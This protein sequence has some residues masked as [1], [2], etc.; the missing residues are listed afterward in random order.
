MISPSIGIS[1]ALFFAQAD[2]EAANYGVCW[3]P[4]LILTAWLSQIWTS[5]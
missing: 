3:D 1:L 4:V 2:F 5:I